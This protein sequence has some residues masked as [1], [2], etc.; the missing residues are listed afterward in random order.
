LTV[1]QR[2]KGTDIGTGRGAE[3]WKTH[4]RQGNR[5]PGG[6]GKM[7]LR[8][9]EDNTDKRERAW[10]AM[11]WKEGNIGARPRVSGSARV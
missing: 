11:G 8:K 5:K 1:S 4:R 6:T 2:G 7:R 3:K 9:R 10:V